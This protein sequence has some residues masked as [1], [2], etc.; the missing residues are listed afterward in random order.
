MGN[1]RMARTGPNGAAAPIIEV[2]LG[3]AGMEILEVNLRTTRF[4]AEVKRLLPS[5][6]WPSDPTDYEGCLRV[7]RAT[8]TSAG[9]AACLVEAEPL[10]LAFVEPDSPYGLAFVKGLNAPADDHAVK[11]LLLLI[12]SIARTTKYPN[13]GDYVIPVR[14]AVGAGAT[15]RPGF[16]NSKEFFSHTDLSYSEAPPPFMALQCVRNN[17]REGGIS[18][19]TDVHDVLRQLTPE[20]IAVLEQP[21]FLFPAPAHYGGQGVVKK[22]ILH[23]TQ[24]FVGREIRFRRDCLRCDSRPAMEAMARLCEVVEA[25]TVELFLEEGTTALVNN[26]RVLH[27]RT[28]FLGGVKA[29]PR[30]INRLYFQPKDQ[31]DATHGHAA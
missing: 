14:E 2:P 17:R 1:A 3:G 27:A 25:T 12:E 21:H 8:R 24:G 13:E 30:H 5:V 15:S 9:L 28:A 10:L 26:R 22:P 29:H 7:A 18:G 19:F 11:S 4:S 20:E 23:Q 16:N 6:A 31:E